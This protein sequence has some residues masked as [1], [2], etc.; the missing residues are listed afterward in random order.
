M[1]FDPGLNHKFCSSNKN[2]ALSDLNPHSNK[3]HKV[4]LG[5]FV[6]I[7]FKTFYGDSY[8]DGEYFLV[9]MGEKHRMH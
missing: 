5:H 4:L 9:M 3:S 1:E 6:E 8:G 2:L 7:Y